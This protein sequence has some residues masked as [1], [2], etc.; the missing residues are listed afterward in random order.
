MNKNKKQLA[1]HGSHVRRQLSRA[2][3]FVAWRHRL[4]NGAG[5]MKMLLVLVLFG[6]FPLPGFAADYTHGQVKNQME[7]KNQTLTLDKPYVEFRYMGWNQTGKHDKMKW[8]RFYVTIKEQNYEVGWFPAA[9]NSVT[10]VNPGLGMMEVAKSEKTGDVHY[11]TVRFY[12]TTRLM[13]YGSWSFRFTGTWDSDDNMEKEGKL[14]KQDYYFDETITPTVGAMPA[15]IKSVT[16]EKYEAGKLQLSGFSFNSTFSNTNNFKRYVYVNSR[17]GLLWDGTYGKIDA[18]QGYN[19][20]MQLTSISRINNRIPFTVYLS[21]AYERTQTV[22]DVKVPQQFFGNYI[23]ATV[24]GCPYVTNLRAELLQWDKKVKL[25]W[26]L[27]KD[28]SDYDRDGKWIIFRYQKSAGPGTRQKIAEVDLGTT[29]FNAD[30]DKY[31]DQYVYEVCFMRNA[32]LKNNANPA[33][34]S[35][36]SASTTISTK[37]D[38]K[39]VL[40]AAPTKNSIVL[41]WNYPVFP[42][43]NVSFKVY[44]KTDTERN[45]KTADVVHNNATAV[46]SSYTIEN[47]SS[48]Y[49]IYTCK[50]ELTDLDNTFTSNEVQDSITGRSSVTSI[51]VSKGMYSNVVKVGWTAEQIGNTNTRYE[52]FRRLLGTTDAWNKIYS[53]SGTGDAYNYDDNTAAPGQYYEYKVEASTNFAKNGQDT[54]NYFSNALTD[55]GFSVSTGTITGRIAYGTG[56]A[57]DSVRVNLVQSAGDDVS[58]AQFYSLRV[59]DVGGGIYLPL[60]T[61]QAKALYGQNQPFTVQMWVNFDEWIKVDL[62]RNKG[63]AQPM[64]FDIYEQ[65]S[66]YSNRIHNKGAEDGYLLALRYPNAEEKL[67]Y[68]DVSTQKLLLK[69]GK[70]YNVVVSHDGKRNWTM[71]LIDEDGNLQKETFTATRDVSF[72]KNNSKTGLTF[73]TNLGNVPQHRF[74]GY[75]DEIRVWTKDLTDAELLRT[76]NHQLTGDE[77]G[78]YL[79]YNLDEGIQNQQTAYDYSRT[80]GV[81]NG[82]HGII[83]P[84]SAVS[85]VVPP[86]SAFSVFG[87]TDSEGNYVIKGVP[88]SG[89]GTNYSIVPTYGVHSFSPAKS[90]RFVSQS[91][92]NH[93]G[94]DFKDVSSFP[95]SGTVYYENTDYPVEGANLYVDGVIC[96]KDGEVIA[97][98]AQG[99]YTIDVPIGDHFIQ[100]KKNGHTFVNNGRYP[101]DANNAGTRFTFEKPISNLRFT[102]NTKVVVTGRVAGGSIEAAKPLGL[103]LGEANIGKAVIK[104]SAGTYRMNVLAETVQGG[105]Q[106]AKDTL[107]YNSASKDV[108]SRAYVEGGDGDK[109]KSI[110]I[111]TDPKTGEFAALLPPVEYKVESVIIPSNNGDGGVKI[112]AQK[113]STINATNAQLVQTDSVDTG[114]RTGETF[115]YCAKLVVPYYVEPKLIVTQKDSKAFGDE[116]YTYQEVNG[117]NKQTFKLWEEKNG[118]LTYNYGQPIFTQNNSYTFNIEGYEEYVNK[119]N[120]KEVKVSRVPLQ[121]SVVTIKNEFAS[122]QAV[123]PDNAQVKELQD[124]QLSLD[125]LGKAAYT[126]VAGFPNITSPYTRSLNITYESGSATKEWSENKTF[127]A[128]VLGELPTGSNFVTSGPDKV[129]MVLRDPPGS[130]SNA[131]YEE[132]TSVSHTTSYDGSFIRDNEVTTLTKLGQSFTVWHG[133]G[134][135]IINTIGQTFD[136]TVGAQVNVEVTKNNTTTETI[137]TTKRI[138]TDDSEDYV[139]A[140]GD[141]FIGSA[142]NVLFGNARKVDFVKQTDGS[143]K[144]DMKNGITTGMQYGTGFNY[145]QNYVE[146]TLLPNFEKLRD[147]LLQL[148]GTVSG[149]TNSTK[150][151]IYVSKLGKDDEKFG[152]DNDDKEVWGNKAAQNNALD[153]PSYT[154]I[155]PSDYETAKDDAG[156]KKVYQ[157]KVRWYNQ[158]IKLWKQLLADNE[159]A[160]YEAKQNRDRY[161]I[162]NTSFSAG[163]TIENSVSVTTGKEKTVT[164]QYEVLA[165]VGGET[166]FEVN[167]KAGLTVTMMTTTGTRQTV[168]TGSGTEQTKTMGYTLKENGDDDAL[169]VDIFNAPDGFGPIFL[170]KGGQTSCPFED[171]YVTKYYQPGTELSAA[172]MQI[173]MPEISVENAFATDVPSGGVAN[174]TLIMRNN[175]ETGEDVWFQLSQIDESNPDGAKLT[176]DG[177]ALTDGRVFL[178]PA[179]KELRKQLQLTQTDQSKLDYENIKLTLRSQ[180]QS[181]PTGVW[182]VIADTVAITAKFVPSCSD[183]QLSIPKRVVNTQTGSKLQMTVKG[184]DR[185]FGSFQGFRIQYKGARDVDWTT[186]KTYVKDE[187]LKSRYKDAEVLGDGGSTEYTFDMTNSALYPDQT[188]VFRAQTM[189]L[190]SNTETNNESDEITV[191]KD[192][193]RP[194]LLGNT[195]PAN[196]ILGADGE[197][198]LNFNED[199]KASSLTTAANF[200]VN[201]K[202]NGYKVDHDV[203]LQLN[204]A[205]AAR[206]EA[207]VDLS[208]RPFALNFWVRYTEAGLLLSH[209][210][211]TNKLKLSV[212]GEGHLVAD[213]A[214]KK[215]TSTQTLPKNKWVF[216][217][218][219]YN[220]SAGKSQLTAN[221]A[222]DATD[223]KLIDAAAPDYDGNGVIAI[224]GGM[225]GALHELTLWDTNRSWAEAQLGR[226]TAKTASTAHL[227]GYWKLNEGMGTDAIDAARSRNMTLGA[228]NWYFAAANKSLAFDGKAHADIDI[229]ACSPSAED[230]YALEM[231]FRGTRPE[232]GKT[233]TLF[234]VNGDSIAAQFTDQGT[235]QLI[236]GGKVTT[237]TGETKSSL[238]DRWHHFALN[239]LANGSVTALIDGENVVQ[240]APVRPFHFQADKLVLGA[241]RKPQTAGGADYAFSNYFKGNIDEV[242]LWNAKLSADVL[243]NRRNIRL[244]GTEPG[245]AAYYPMETVKFDDYGQATVTA[246]FNNHCAADTTKRV[247]TLTAATASDEAPGMKSAPK[248]DKV[249]FDFTASERRVV[250]NLLESD[251]ALEGTTVNITLRDVRDANDNLS[252]PVS[253]SAYIKRNQ[254]TWEK[255]AHALTIERGAG[256]TFTVQ[257]SNMSG[258]PEAWT[259]TGLPTWLT[260]DAENGQLAALGTRPLKF[261]VPA[262]TAIGHYDATVYLTGNRGIAEP[263]TVQL[264]VTGDKPEWTVNPHDF[265]NTMTLIGELKYNG[266]PGEDEEDIVAAFDQNGRCIGLQHPVY[267]KRYDRYF[268]MMTIYSNGDI[269]GHDITFRVWD[270][271]TGEIHSKVVPSETITVASNA[272]YGTVTAPVT[273]NAT[274]LLE[275]QLRLARGWQWKSLFVKPETMT[276]E[277]VFAPVLAKT[278]TVK[279]QNSY[280]MMKNGKTFG[281]LKDMSVTTMYRINMADS[282]TLRVTGAKLRPNDEQIALNKGWNWLGYTPG[283]SASPAYALAPANP[284]DGDVIKSQRGFAYYQDYEWIGTLSAMEPGEG[285]M[286]KASAARTFNYPSVAPQRMSKAQ[287]RISRVDSVWHF[288]KPD[289]YAYPNTMTVTSKVMKDGQEVHGADVGF[290]ID[291]VN[292]AS[293]EEIDEWYFINVTHL[294]NNI[295]IKI[296]VWIPGEDKVYDSPT[297]LYYNDDAIV[298][299]LD[300]PFIIN[301]GTSTGISD[302]ES[303]SV[304]ITPRRAKDNVVVTSGSPIRQVR[305]FNMQGAAVITD[306]PSDAH[307][308]AISVSSLPNGIYFVDVLTADGRHTRQRIAKVD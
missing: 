158:Q 276:V 172:T 148:P 91:S 67:G 156:K 240:F 48:A 178:V 18:V 245:L 229:T 234:S 267:N 277:S 246:D 155:L 306:T 271:S 157:D 302:V 216:M 194:R 204:A 299:D 47:V 5:L 24:K 195:S 199:I 104:L 7:W 4:L 243:R 103:G 288:G 285:Y 164:Q 55:N 142:T 181:D 197:I 275:Q 283:F 257:I 54:K 305:V 129:L 63:N 274:D 255:K 171:K 258:T 266:K 179:G 34:V 86:A 300:N 9:M 269:N 286:Y 62:N 248:L 77:K 96:T 130:N 139:G 140:N 97:T 186:A 208:Y 290:F 250:I 6:G 247:I 125:S 230:S 116:T 76:Y 242:R 53:T 121:N 22:G 170:T 180:C 212:D 256:A 175:S 144:L 193:A 36:L 135:G 232:T 304:N 261:S 127:K 222:Y 28:V 117:N 203:A 291:G 185:N 270:A 296:K 201:G 298:G 112:D 106:N 31:N 105:I 228:A 289:Y 174:Y 98:D 165:V 202:L 60:D 26:Q 88:F 220:Y 251:E 297:Q 119:D 124:N 94:V 145:T 295:P 147:E 182:P 20:S 85:T 161:L 160:K 123:D 154:M 78:L 159:K 206:T 93:S 231:W 13:Q 14:G 301:V 137:T 259:V 196:G 44:Y 237:A 43:T 59:N 84:S 114:E 122:G 188:Y 308:T 81:A 152:S 210:S 132:G 214:G 287:R 249:N 233:A 115:S 40:T 27:G 1:F 187:K 83:R 239:V 191:V 167:A 110:Y 38:M 52:V 37:P 293:S 241:M 169:S 35:D 29:T 118:K 101:Q 95:V 45:W 183:I 68:K 58:K 209:G 74:Q 12:P 80:G 273:L 32:W 2:A 149:N 236:T 19:T 49:D 200:V 221:A 11:Y 99:R 16:L 292:W 46:S 279:S 30:F 113:L 281:A 265:E 263:L 42:H 131:F 25:S 307:R 41:N 166:G 226:T 3:S 143:F 254:L 87:L 244:E 56:T 79:Y 102:D 262:S 284:Q 153:G 227:I 294:G 264:H 146:N 219:S 17:T 71:R 82:H 213:I 66:I 89:N 23:S 100:I 109:V 33:L 163:T 225:K 70:F 184:Y 224:G 280:A 211:T 207:P 190:I 65:H 217:Q 50:V 92:L 198:A 138:S 177:Q 150:E 215:L 120:A 64:L 69:P 278:S 218:T 192:M 128:I 51:N 282:A 141:V 126:F 108:N 10:C 268:T 57:V 73:G 235:L 176:I 252:Q 21:T 238:D 260:L 133:V 111:V 39:I 134:S 303:G 272:I 8:I 205:E 168:A 253:W 151:A 189:C 15:N 136:L 72:A 90:S 75:I 173:E 223:V 162:E 107:F 61:T